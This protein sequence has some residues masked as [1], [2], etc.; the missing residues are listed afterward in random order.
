MT[1][2]TLRDL[3]VVSGEPRVHDIVLGQRLG[4]ER[5]RKVRELIH[6]NFAELKRYGEVSPH[7]GAKP[8]LGSKGGRPQSG[9]LLNEGQALLVCMFADTDRAAEV[10]E[11]VIRVFMAWRAGELQAA[12]QPARRQRV[13]PP[14]SESDP[15]H[16]KFRDP[17]LPVDNRR[18]LLERL[19]GF[20]EKR[21]DD[22]MIRTIAHL[23]PPSGPSGK[24]K[25]PRFFH[26][27]DVLTAVVTTHRQ[28]TIDRVHEQLVANFSWRA[29]SRSSLA[30]FWLRLDGLFGTGRKLH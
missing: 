5:P 23:L 21:A 24:I 17:L 9:F 1:A 11:Q 20:D 4:F 16:P 6:R 29:P 26:D 3:S 18:A 14:I 30:R 10:R 8:Q 25:W 22:R 2:L 19:H 28:A 27:K 15:R 13:A 7:R 12:P